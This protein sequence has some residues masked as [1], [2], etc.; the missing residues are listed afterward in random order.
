MK[1]G[2]VPC[3]ACFGDWFHISAGPALDDRTNR[4]ERLTHF[5]GSLGGNGMLY[6]FG[7]A[8]FERLGGSGVDTERALEALRRWRIAWLEADDP[9][10]EGRHPL[11]DTDSMAARRL[12]ERLAVKP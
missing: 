2:S 9:N 8:L 4:L 12:L 1:D 11:K 5:A 10:V 6:D 7:Y 3:P